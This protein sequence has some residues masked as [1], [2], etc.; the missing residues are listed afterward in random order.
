MRCPNS[1]KPKLIVS[2]LKSDNK[3]MFTR[4]YLK[5]KILFQDQGGAE[6]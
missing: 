4:S 6:F 5:I 1:I 3:Y 2:N